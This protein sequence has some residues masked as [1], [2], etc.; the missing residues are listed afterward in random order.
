ML[1]L[2]GNKSLF[3]SFSSE[4]EQKNLL[5][6]K[7]KKRKDFHSLCWFSF[8]ALL[9]T[10]VCAA[11]EEPASRVAQIFDGLRNDPLRLRAFLA[12]MPKGGDLHNHLDG[13]IYAEDFLDH[14]RQAGLCI[15]L[16][17]H[18]IRPAPCTAQA[19]RADQALAADPTLENTM[20]DA[21]SMRNFFRR[22]GDA[23]G[24]DHFFATF[25]KFHAAAEDIGAS[26]VIE[27]RRAAA[28]H[29]AYLEIIW[30]PHIRDAI[31]LAKST[32]WQTE[33][34]AQD[35]TPIAPE[36]ARLAARAKQ[37][38]DQALS[39]M[40]ATL[41]CN[42]KTP[43]PACQV[44]IRFLA[45][46][47]RT[48]PPQAVFAQIAY[49][50]A[51]VQSDPNFVG[52]N[53]VAPE[54]DPVALH[55][56]TLHMR[57]L[58]FFHQANPAI[59]LS[60]HAGELAFGLVPPDDLRFHIRQAVE[61]AE[62]S[63]I[64]HGVDVMYETDA[65][66]LLAEMAR[67]HIAVEINQTSNA[68]ILG[69]TGPQH[70]FADYRA[71]HVPVVIS[72]DDEGVERTDLTQEYVRAAETW[73]LGYRDLKALAYD[74]ILYS[75]LPDAN[76]KPRLQAKLEQQFKIFEQTMIRSADVAQHPR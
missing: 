60:L 16:T 76:E 29:I 15:D 1:K 45:Y 72:T 30:V 13:S 35:L 40:H 63:R 33:N 4:K 38:V 55:D 65:A 59:K 14:A 61:I 18:A 23:S 49:D 75:F 71:A 22:P 66:S 32:G 6:L 26:L 56:Y 68:Q 43:E 25:A 17:A 67:Q 50:F 2:R 64:G 69:I 52:V 74:S 58:R 42:T 24:H 53:I 57:M 48:L 62:A 11:A 46:S 7:K 10:L 73:H 36:I 54:D 34:F 44:N 12:D 3:G 31:K 27:A 21:L 5:F 28:E 20:I 41:G 39:E 8:A 47:L 70:P 19:P 9:P 37:T 51:V